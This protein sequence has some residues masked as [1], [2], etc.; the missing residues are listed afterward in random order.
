MY[1]DDTAIYVSGNSV[2]EITNDL[3]H[4]LDIIEKW[5]VT[6]KLF[7]NVGKTR[8]MLFGSQHKLSNSNGLD[9]KINGQEVEQ[10]FKFK[11]LGSIW[12]LL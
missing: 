2:T 1:A 11:Y 4:D 7:L 6:N 9:L 5:L 12:I 3:K 8:S 10:V